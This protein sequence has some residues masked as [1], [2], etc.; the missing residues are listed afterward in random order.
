MLPVSSLI[1]GAV[2][3]GTAC[4]IISLAAVFVFANMM[5][6]KALSAVMLVFGV[7]VITGSP[8]SIH[9]L[10]GNF[11]VEKLTANSGFI[12]VLSF[13]LCALAWNS[14]Y[15]GNSKCGF[16]KGVYCALV[17]AATG[18]FVQGHL[19]ARKSY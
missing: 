7:I 2:S 3:F 5:V 4:T 15:V 9:I 13:L 19:G 10:L 17:A 18:F 1:V 14:Y 6:F 16:T 12:P 8:D 11:G